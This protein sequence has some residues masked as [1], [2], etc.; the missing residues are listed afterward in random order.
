MNEEQ[1]AVWKA[2]S[3]PT[4]RAIL[5]QLREGPKTTTEIVE[6]FPDMTRFAVMKHM[7]V[8]RSATL[9]RTRAD[10]RRKINSLNV[11]PIRQIYE[12]WVSPFQ[13]MWASQLADLKRTLEEEIQ[14][15]K[16]K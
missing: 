3:D 11:V 7:E 16:E 9:L 2:L 13:D 1:D 5:E 6:S 12:H 8:L 4:R 10:G 15:E 14:E